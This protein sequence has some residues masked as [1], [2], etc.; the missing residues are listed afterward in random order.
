MKFRFLLFAF[1]IVSV[2]SA[3][4]LAAERK[5][6]DAEITSLLTDHSLYADGVEQMFQ[7][8][9]ATFYLQGS[10]SSQGAW[11]VE[12]GRYCSQWPPNQSWACYDVL[13]DGDA[14][15]FVSGEGKR[16]PMRLT[17]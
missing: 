9:G 8:S 2:V 10:S 14:V 3:A 13:R 12:E 11:K 1:L 5:L 6:S 17:K 7:A 4:V 15:T 16:F